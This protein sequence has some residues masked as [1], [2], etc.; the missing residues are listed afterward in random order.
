MVVRA[1]ISWVAFGGLFYNGNCFLITLIY[2]LKTLCILS[3]C[4]YMSALTD[5]NLLVL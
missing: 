2:D 1:W 5:E 3:G 4:L